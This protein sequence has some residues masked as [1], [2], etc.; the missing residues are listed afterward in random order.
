MSMSMEASLQS[1]EETVQGKQFFLM[2]ILMLS[3]LLILQLGLLI[4][5]SEQ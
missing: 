1:S 4:L 2:D 5:L 3:L